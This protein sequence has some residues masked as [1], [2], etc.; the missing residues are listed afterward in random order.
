MSLAESPFPWYAVTVKH[1]HEKSVAQ[2]IEGKGF[3]HFLPVY[4]KRDGGAELPVFP[5]YVFCSL[6]I[7]HRLPILT[8]PGV[9]TFVSIARVPAVIS[10]EELVSVERMIQSDL[11]I[12]PHPF[13][14]TGD[15][16]YIERGPLQGMEGILVSCKPHARLVVS[17]P[18][19]QRS[20]AAEVEENWVRPATR[21]T[22]VAA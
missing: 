8:I 7:T 5:N 12:G 14:C 20:V 19:L 17:V 13:L 22:S 11:R 2:A 6:D 3:A 9:S 21:R 15:R 10:A 18:M 16:V 4:R 1:H